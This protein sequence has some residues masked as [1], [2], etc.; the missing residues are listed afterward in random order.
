MRISGNLISRPDLTVVT[1]S[2]LSKSDINSALSAVSSQPSFAA[3]ITLNTHRK[4]DSPFAPQVSPPRFLADLCANVC[5]VLEHA[6]IHRIVLMSTASS[7]QSTRYAVSARVESLACAH[8]T[9]SRH[10]PPWPLEREGDGTGAKIHISKTVS[11]M[12]R[13]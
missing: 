3:I 12:K 13:F 11:Q 4:S 9:T 7:A 6:D 10:T 8:S 1:R 5:E 2:P